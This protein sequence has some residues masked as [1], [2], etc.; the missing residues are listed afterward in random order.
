LKKFALSFVLVGLL[1]VLPSCKQVVY[2]PMYQ[3]GSVSHVVLCYLKNKGNAADRQKILEAT[4]ALREIPG[5]YDI[6]VGY[7][8]PSDRPVVVSDY[9]VGM[10]ITFRDEAALRAYA[11]HPK[12][13]QA[14]KEV[15]EPLTSKIVV[16]DF[17]NQEY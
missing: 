3:K 15:L 17:V 14:T 13:Q 4:R 12:H 7:V 10:V 1:G 6:E 8:L 9:D 5:V 2:A 11:N 16:Y